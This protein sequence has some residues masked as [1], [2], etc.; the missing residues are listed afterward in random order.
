MKK[1]VVIL[2]LLIGSS[3]FA[4]NVEKPVTP[5]AGDSQDGLTLVCTTGIVIFKVFPNAEEVTFSEKGLETK[6][7]L[8]GVKECRRNEGKYF[9]YHSNND[10]M[11]NISL[12]IGSKH[13]DDRVTVFINDHAKNSTENGKR[14]SCLVWKNK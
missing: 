8:N 2:G 9:C 6:A 13:P 5:A 1:I 4:A 10:K 3:S 14:Y 11:I 12:D 7:K